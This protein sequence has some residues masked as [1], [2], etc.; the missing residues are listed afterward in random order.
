[1]IGI[2]SALSIV[3]DCWID[4]QHRLC[5]VSRSSLDYLLHDIATLWTKK[6][7]AQEHVHTLFEKRTLGK[8]AQCTLQ[9]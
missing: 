8:E 7:L 6:I 9:L 3:K 1:M 4:E 5:L 2:R